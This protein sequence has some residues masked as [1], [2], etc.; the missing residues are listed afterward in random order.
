MC[1][2]AHKAIRI[3]ICRS[4][5]P[6]WRCKLSAGY[7]AACGTTE[8]WKLSSCV[9]RTRSHPYDVYNMFRKKHVFPPPGR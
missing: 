7:P 3:S 6:A 4:T 9:L 5:R 8:V 2:L 1:R